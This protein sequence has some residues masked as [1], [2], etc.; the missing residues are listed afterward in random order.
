MIIDELRHEYKLK[1]LLQVA[2]IK[3]STYEYYKSKKH[4]RYIEK[5]NKEEKELLGKISSIFYKPL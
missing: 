2:N 3:K 1:V 4:I 5:K